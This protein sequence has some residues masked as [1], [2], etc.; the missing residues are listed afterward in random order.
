MGDSPEQL[1]V[2][3]RGRERYGITWD[4]QL[5]LHSRRRAGDIGDTL[6]LV[7][8]EPVITVGRQGDLANLLLS[9]EL[10]AQRGMDFHRVERGGD[11]TYHGPGQLVGYPIMDLKARGLTV[12]ELMR[13]LEEAL[14][15]TSA[16]F[17]ITAGRQSGL[18]GVWRGEDKLAALGVAVKNGVSF[19]GFALNIA[20]DLSYFE[21]IVPCGITDKRVASLSGLARREITV[22]EARLRVVEHFK[23][24]FDYH[25]KIVG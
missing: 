7:E 22:D 20:T 15:R 5:Q 14:I 2:E 11:V 6:I 10:L 16:D 21:L 1:E 3:W 8:H 24:V 18:T 12:R 17:G 9:E 25:G 4:Y 13:G 19:H 23:D